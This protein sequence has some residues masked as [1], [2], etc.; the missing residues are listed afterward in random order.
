MTIDN[1]PRAAVTPEKVSRSFGC[2]F[3]G[4]G[5]PSLLLLLLVA[6]FMIWTARANRR[7]ARA[8]ATK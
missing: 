7:A 2:L 8:L 3:V 1:E 5:L 4:L 6:L